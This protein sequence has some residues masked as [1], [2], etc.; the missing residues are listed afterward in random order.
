MRINH[1]DS[2]EFIKEWQYVL[3]NKKLSLYYLLNQIRPKGKIVYE[4]NPFR[5]LR[6]SQPMDSSGLRPGE[7][8][9][10]SE[11]EN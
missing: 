10:N 3:D 2:S 9:Y 4:Y 5:N 8:G 1:K 6:L 11:D 7:P